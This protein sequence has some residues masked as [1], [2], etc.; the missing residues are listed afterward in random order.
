MGLHGTETKLLRGPD[1][2]DR[3]LSPIGDEQGPDLH[4]AA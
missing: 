2:P 1:D 4:N 3:D